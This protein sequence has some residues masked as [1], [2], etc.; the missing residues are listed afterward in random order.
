MA[1]VI[2]RSQFNVPAPDASSDRQ[3]G[4]RP[5][6]HARVLGLLVLRAG[7][8]AAVI[9]AVI[10][11]VIAPIRG[12]FAGEF[13][14]FA[15]Y[16]AAARSVVHH[17]DLYSQFIHQPP[18]VALTG[19]DY[20]P[21]VAFLVQPLAWIPANAA[22]TLWLWLTIACTAAAACIA[23]FTLL[24]RGW[25]RIEI[26][27]L[28]T[29]VFSAAT[30][31]YWHGQM[32]PVIFLL[33]ALA[34]HAWVHGHQTRFG[35]LI[36][37]AA[38][39]KLAPILLIVLVI[40]RRWWRAAAACAV[41]VAVGLGVGVVTL[42]VSTLREYVTH[43]LPVLS[44]QDGWLYNQS[45][46]GVVSRLFGHAVLVPQAGSLLISL[47]TYV[48]LVAM[49][50]LLVFCVSPEVRNRQ[51]RGA[52]F[53]A[54]TLLM[55]LASTITWYA[56]YVNAIIVVFAVVALVVVGREWRPRA[57]VWSTVAFA[58]AVAV[59]APVLIANV[60]SAAQL[61][62]LSHTSWWWLLTQVA[63]LPALTATALFVAL[64]GRLRRS[65]A[66]T[67]SPSVQTASPAARALR[68]PA[69]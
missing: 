8:A 26:A 30:Y 22:A 48:V 47:I 14:D 58:V 4:D 42:G 13:E 27:A 3:G 24:P 60:T 62:M 61:T 41:T 11:F 18:N 5:D 33:L 7:A 49:L 51:V 35:V 31:N 57:L 65:A 36:G 38:S 55:L 45:I 23:A 19:F 17:T 1:E 54:G 6:A 69:G 20:P 67:A 32:N 66:S 63:S 56:H 68:A 52:E 15:A 50:G 25:P 59:V 64:T 10:T 37:I 34:V 9:G 29:C 28:V 53:A 2:D 46:S 12:T 21:V 43:V 16:L 39:I 40:R 44:A